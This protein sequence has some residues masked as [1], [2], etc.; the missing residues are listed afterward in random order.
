VNSSGALLLAYSYA[1]T[2]G[3]TSA[4]KYPRLQ[5]QLRRRSKFYQALTFIDGRKV[6]KSLKTDRLSTALKLDHEKNEL[7]Q[8]V[9]FEP[10]DK[11]R[12]PY[13][14]IDVRGKTGH[15]TAI[16]GGLAPVIFASRSDGFKPGDHLWAHGQRDA[17]RELLIAAGLRTDT[18]GNNRNLKSIRAT[19]IS[20]RILAQAPNPD[21]LMIARNAGTSVAMIDQFYAK[22]LS[23]EMGAGQLSS[24]LLG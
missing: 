8:I 10:E 3:G 20:F 6:Q 18:F 23:S 1:D 22:R 24:S 14:V 15:R 12:D 4:P 9:P 2:V 7:M 11:K 16:A 19:A 17:F 5:V 13:V 21:L